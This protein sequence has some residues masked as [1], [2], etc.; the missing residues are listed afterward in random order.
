[1]EYVH[2]VFEHYDDVGEISFY[3]EYM[4]GDEREI[5]KMQSAEDEFPVPEP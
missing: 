1:M 3:T 2:Q 5:W 4:Y